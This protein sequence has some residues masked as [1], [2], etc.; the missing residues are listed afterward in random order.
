MS[1]FMIENG[2]IE[3]NKVEVDNH[4]RL[5]TKA[6]VISHMSHH[7]AY[8]K[9]GFIKN[10]DCTLAGT[11][12]TNIAYLN[13][14]KADSE[15]EIYWLRISSDA[16][17]KITLHKNETY[18]SGGSSVD[19]E[20]TDFGSQITS[21]AQAYEGGASANLT[22]GSTLAKEFDG[23]FLGAN[24]LIDYTYDGGIIIPFTKSMTIKAT[25][26][27]N[28]KVKVVIGF[29]IHGLGTKL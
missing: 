5:Y 3:S 25:G 4:G 6:N 23:F 24:D 21:S 7:A 27:A 26:A 14:N 10:F 13:C 18:S 8:H 19:M 29:S 22:L 15:F 9:N 17:V 1:S 12:A 2:G 11:S 20:N 16:A 28:D